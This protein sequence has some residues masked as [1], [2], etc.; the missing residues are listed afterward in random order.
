MPKTSQHSDSEFKRANTRFSSLATSSSKQA[1][2]SPAFS[3]HLTSPARVIQLQQSIGNQAV[4]RMINGQPAI[5]RTT[6]NQV[7]REETNWAKFKNFAGNQAAGFGSNVGRIGNLVDPR[8]AYSNQAAR[9][10]WHN[11]RRGM[12]MGA[13]QLGIGL[14]LGLAAGA[15]SGVGRGLATLGAGAYYGAKGLGSNIGQ[16]IS[17]LGGALSGAK[18]KAWDPLTSHQQAQVIG[19]VGMGIAAGIS[20][21]GSGISNMAH[22]DI[23]IPNGLRTHSDISLM[24][25]GASL[26]SVSSVGQGF[27]A[28]G[29][30][31][32]GIGGVINMGSGLGNLFGSKAPG[33]G[34]QR[35]TR[36]LGRFMLGGGQA[37][38]GAAAAGK[39]IGTMSGAASP[40]ASF[41]ASAL[42]PAQA[43][44]SGV[45]LIRGSYLL[46]K[47]RK[48]KNVLGAAQT[49]FET[50]SAAPSNED[51]LGPEAG[52]YQQ[53][54]AQ[55]Q[56]AKEYQ[57]KRMR[58]AGLTTA[59]GVLGVVGAGLTL[60]GVG[61]I[62]GVPLMI[63]A[64]LLKAGASL[65]PIIRDKLNSDKAKRKANK[66]TD[67]ARFMAEHYTDKG[68]KRILEGMSAESNALDD[69]KLAAMTL[70][71]RIEV[72]RKQLMKR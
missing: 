62:A 53:L 44:L 38:A 55:A 13:M 35:G 14:P 59:A 64:G 60:S 49:D 31:A 46:N 26:E 27:S 51:A 66:E 39:A 41:L 63:A 9:G 18:K 1:T 45:D 52:Y 36:G 47:A 56:M 21:I 65:G 8:P 6:A 22:G 3:T 32:T 25:G 5:G 19:N 48:R 7:Q 37:F 11:M 57:N 67:W 43:A 4:Q 71:Q 33:K 61:A 58:N 16:G 70:E 10:G 23:T 72:M 28:A 29:G 50:M 2:R 34:Y 15:F 40:A 69:E 12:G 68:V 24:K 17:A 20:A 54:A 30:V 42:I